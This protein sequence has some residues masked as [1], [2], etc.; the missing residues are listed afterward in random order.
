MAKAAVQHACSECG[1]ATG[2]WLG[3]CPECGSWGTLVEERVETKDRRPLAVASRPL[4]R[5]VDVETAE[6]NRLA[7]GIPE[8][9]RVLGGGLVP[10]SLVLVSGDPGIGK[11]T[12]LL[13][14][15]RAMSREHAVVLV[16]G[17]ESTAQVKLRADRL[18]GAG[19]V[20]ILAETNLD[21]ICA[22][23]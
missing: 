12:L 14:M 19:E 7:T 22:V 20:R 16:S 11:S 6:A 3:R 13:M 9:D 5:L 17:E 4:L 23:L 2:K 8:L 21:E 18:G 10:A 15:L 1:Y